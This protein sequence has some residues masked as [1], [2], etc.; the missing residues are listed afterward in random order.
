[1]TLF[2]FY[3]AML[4][5]MTTHPELFSVCRHWCDFP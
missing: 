3:I 2:V 1:M 4:E 5:A